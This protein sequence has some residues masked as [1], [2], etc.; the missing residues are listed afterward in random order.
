MLDTKLIAAHCVHVD[1]GEIRTMR[2]AGT[3]IA[4][5]P[6][7]NLK[8]ASGFAPTA[9]MM[10]MGAK[11]GIGT[12]GA[13]S[14]N[15]LDMF[16]EMRLASLIA[17]PVAGDPTVLPARQVLEMATRIGAEVLHLDHI[18]GSLEVGKRADIIVLDIFPIHNQP[19]SSVILKT[20]MHKLFMQAKPAMLP[21]LWLMASG[22]CEIKLF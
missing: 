5:N 21:M 18:T 2:R 19:I 14:N 9:R 7:S 12:D 10:E 15:D 6:S 22:S 20:F 3:G 16:E 11:V 13:A 8:L 4:H 17:K 1:D